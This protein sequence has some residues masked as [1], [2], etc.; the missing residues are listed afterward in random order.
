[1]KNKYL[2]YVVVCIDD[3][4]RFVTQINNATKYAHWNKDEAPMDF[5]KSTAEDLAYCLNL[6][7]YPSFVLQSYYKIETQI[8]VKKEKKDEE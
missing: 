4:A 3:E 8:F 2:Y 6:N 7:F 5:A 1:M